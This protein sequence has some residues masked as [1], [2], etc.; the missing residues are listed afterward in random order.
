MGLEVVDR[1][2][3]DLVEV[4]VVV[5]GAD[6]LSFPVARLVLGAVDEMM[7]RP[8]R[9]IAVFLDVMLVLSR[10]GSVHVLSIPLSKARG[11]KR[12]H[13]VGAPVEIGRWR[14]VFRKLHSAFAEWP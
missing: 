11:L 13:R 9:G 14:G 8:L 2:L 7:I 10:A 5:M 6:V 4:R 3:H 12:G 1:P